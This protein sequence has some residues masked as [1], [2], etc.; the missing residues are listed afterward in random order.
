MPRQRQWI[1]VVAACFT[2][3]ARYFLLFQSTNMLSL[4]GKREW[5]TELRDSVW[6]HQCSLQYQGNQNTDTSI[7]ANKI[8]LLLPNVGANRIRVDAK[9]LLC[10]S[11]FYKNDSHWNSLRCKLLTSCEGKSC[12]LRSFI[13]HPCNV[14]DSSFIYD[15]SLLFQS[16]IYQ[17]IYQK[18]VMNSWFDAINSCTNNTSCRSSDSKIQFYVQVIDYL[19]FEL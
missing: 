5:S 3:T 19:E 10:P 8:W 18:V 11:V 2:L 4:F 16:P 7:A 1:V 6:P 17:R 14:V 15:V 9:L 13:D 12:Y